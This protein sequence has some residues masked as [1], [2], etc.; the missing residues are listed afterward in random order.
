MTPDPILACIDAGIPFLQSSGRSYDE[1][2]FD[3]RGFLT[4]QEQQRINLIPRNKV[5]IVLTLGEGCT[6]NLAGFPQE[7][8]RA[9]NQTLRRHP[10]NSTNFS[11]TMTAI[12]ELVKEQHDIGYVILIRDGERCFPRS[13]NGFLSDA[14]HILYGRVARLGRTLPILRTNNTVIIEAQPGTLDPAIERAATQVLRPYADNE[15]VTRIIEAGL[16]RFPN[17]QLEE[18]LSLEH[19]ARL[20]S[21]TST[22]DIVM[23]LR[24]ADRTG[25]PITAEQL[26]TRKQEAV[27]KQTEGVLTYLPPRDHVEMYG[28]YIKLVKEELEAI[29]AHLAAGN[30]DTP[31]L[32]VL[33]GPPGVG[34]TELLIKLAHEAGIPVFELQSMLNKWQGES[35]RLSQLVHT[36]RRE[37]APTAVI[38]D[39]G[40]NI[41]T[42]RSAEH[43][44]GTSADLNRDW[45]SST[46]GSTMRGK[47][48][49][50]STTN[51]P[52]SNPA[53]MKSRMY[54]I[55]VF[56]PSAEDI[57]VITTHLC[58]AFGYAL[59]DE[60][61]AEM[62]SILHAKMASPRDIKNMLRRLRM[63]EATADQVLPAADDLLIP[64]EQAQA[65]ILCDLRN[66][67]IMGS[68]SMLPWK[69]KQDMP[70]H[71]AVVIDEHG[72]I[73]A[74]LVRQKVAGL[75]HVRV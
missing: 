2:C 17:A 3:E 58:A 75:S 32:V 42:Q 44:G 15:E 65:M 52:E 61:L 31:L 29:L 6:W 43:D 46:T 54:V 7:V 70:P 64:E 37:Q 20:L 9:I 69:E 40:R 18:G 1:V 45:L 11:D 66:L 39:E 41:S 16:E 53:A 36:T 56:S 73:K 38:A 62:A 68:R 27:Q 14:Q 49:V 30:K 5:Q 59:D 48:T 57:H 55:P 67:E 19:A 8:E 13:E 33:A 71:I 12:A 50:F 34:K 72:K 74:D 35:Q 23:M 24:G 60:T 51:V 4:D 10:L 21:H 63:H 25:E 26:K 22:F 28:Q 47:S